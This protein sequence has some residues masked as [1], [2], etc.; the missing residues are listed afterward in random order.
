MKWC[1][2]CEKWGNHYRAGYP[3]EEE[4]KEEEAGDG[5]GHVTIE[6]GVEE[7]IDDPPPSEAFTRLHVA[8]L[9]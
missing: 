7:D 3:S 4:A 1:G 6:D 9:V 8:D 2:L 5:D